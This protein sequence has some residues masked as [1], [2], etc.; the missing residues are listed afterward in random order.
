LFDIYTRS[1]D[2][3]DVARLELVTHQ[4]V[5]ATRDVVKALQ[6]RN[7]KPARMSKLLA[8]AGLPLTDDH[9]SL[10]RLRVLAEL[11]NCLEH[12]VGNATAEFLAFVPQQSLGVGDLIPVG[13]KEVGEALAVIEAVA[14]SLNR[15]SRI[16]Y[17]NRS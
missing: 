2:I 17:D 12:N 16:L 1:A 9:E 5:L 11:R 13:P 8:D 10:R 14:S 7:L 6:E 4:H 3:P 15:R